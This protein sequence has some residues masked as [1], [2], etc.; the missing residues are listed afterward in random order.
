MNQAALRLVVC[1]K[2]VNRQAAELTADRGDKVALEA[3]LRLREA[4]RAAPGSS[5]GD[6][7]ATITVLMMGPP[8]AESVARQCLALGADEAYLLCDRVLAGSDAQATARALAAAIRHLG[9]PGG[10]DLILTGVASSDGGTG[11][12]GPAVA[13]LLGIDF[14][15]RAAELAFSGAP[16][17]EHAAGAGLGLRA[18]T[19]GGPVE[20]SFP[21]LATVAR[22]A[23]TPRQTTMLGIVQARSRP[24]TYLD[25]AAVGLDSATVG[26]RGSATWVSRLVP[27][28]TGR[29]AEMIGGAV[30]EQAEAVAALLRSKRLP[31]G[32][33]R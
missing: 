33:H 4:L 21:V 18:G 30:A 3:A 2:P 27:H 14:V 13:T 16:G 17:H 9:G 1:V 12:V 26:Q 23:Y 29:R 22:A 11:Q 25:C 7:L 5:A 6:T 24:L 8:A 32:G 15:N 31:P 10:F 28:E 20:A 19:V